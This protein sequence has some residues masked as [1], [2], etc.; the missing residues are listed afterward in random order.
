MKDDVDTVIGFL[1]IP[2]YVTIVPPCLKTRNK[3]TGKK[4]THYISQR[5]LD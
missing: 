2:P 3:K 4:K 5:R 1:D